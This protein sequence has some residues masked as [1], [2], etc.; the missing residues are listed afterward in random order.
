[1]LI[2][3]NFEQQIDEISTSRKGGKE[4]ITWQKE[5]PGVLRGQ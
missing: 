3:L 5:S 4:I 1:M 2:V